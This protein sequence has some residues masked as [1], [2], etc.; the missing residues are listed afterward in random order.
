MMYNKKAHIHFVGIGGIGMSGIAH[1]LKAQGYTISGCDLDLKQK[2]VQ[3]LIDAL[4]YAIG[5]KDIGFVDR[6]R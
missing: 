2:S 5:S 4:L 6:A 3:N 1:I